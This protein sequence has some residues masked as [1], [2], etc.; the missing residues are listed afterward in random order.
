M[1][2]GPLAG[3]DANP[4][5]SSAGG[6]ASRPSSGWELTGWKPGNDPAGPGSE[7][8]S[9]P[10]PPEKGA[11]KPPAPEVGWPNPG[12]AA[13]EAGW[14]NWGPD[15]PEAGWLKPGAAPLNFGFG[16]AES[17]MSVSSS[18]CGWAGRPYTAPRAGAAAGGRP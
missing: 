7:L 13:P 12:L 5:G 4:A 17:G 11:G 8:D 2:G 18:N 10:R 9:C 6:G 3:G 1:A 15:A 16:G 14:L